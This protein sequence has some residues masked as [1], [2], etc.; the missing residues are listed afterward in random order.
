GS[1]LTLGGDQGGTAG[2]QGHQVGNPIWAEREEGGGEGVA[3]R[4]GFGDKGGEQVSA[5]RIAGARVDHM[6]V[7]PFP[8]LKPFAVR[9]GDGKRLIPQSDLCYIFAFGPVGFLN[10]N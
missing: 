6:T 2:A 9:R 4:R 8:A 5:G 7:L 1:L 10:G 3:F